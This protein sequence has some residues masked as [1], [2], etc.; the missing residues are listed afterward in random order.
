MKKKLFVFYLVVSFTLILSNSFFSS[1]I[2]RLHNSVIDLEF[3]DG[4]LTRSAYDNYFDWEN[5][6]KVDM[7]NGSGSMVKDVNLPWQLG[8]SNMGVPSE[9]IDENIED[10]YSKRMYTKRNNWELLYSNV[11]ETTSYKYIV[12]YN[13]LTGILRCFY[14]ILSDPSSTGTTNSVWGIGANTPT[15]LFNFTNT[16]AE[17][18]SLRKVT[19]AYI[20]TPVGSIVGTA[21]TSVGFQNQ[22]W[23]GLEIECA[24]DP[25][26]SIGSNKNFYL[27]GRAIDKITYN[28]I[29]TS[30]GNIEGSITST[31]PAGAGLSMNFSNMFN[32]SNSISITNQKSAIEATGD[33]IEEGLKQ[34]DSFFNSLWSNVKSN[35]GKWAVAGL[36]AGVKQGLSAIVS[37]GGS[38][39]ANVLGGLFSSAT[40]NNNVSKVDLKM[41]MNSEYK[42]EGEKV[43]PGWT[44]C[45][46]PIPGTKAESQPNKPLYNL[47]LGV[48]NL[49]QTPIVNLRIHAKN[50]YTGTLQNP[51][52]YNTT[53]YTF[54]YSLESSTNNIS[55]IVINP[56]VSNLLS[57]EN[58]KFELIA[59]KIPYGLSKKGIRDYPAYSFLNDEEY[60]YI[61]TSIGGDEE[62]RS[63]DIDDYSHAIAV[64]PSSSL[65]LLIRTSFELLNKETGSRLYVSKYFS[66][67]IVTSKIV[68]DIYTG[69]NVGPNV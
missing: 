44:D 14:Y 37:S 27:M 56:N 51:G 59:S 61:G 18:A 26:T 6:T 62:N 48:W 13:R 60:Y 45:F 58:V 69:S 4:V 11:S 17:D 31:A 42:F 49:I 34:N 36:E 23:Y 52:Y 43:L 8:V 21:Y 7:I 1:C 67:K 50:Q 54:S 16:I 41:V 46:L 10:E 28:G 32:K 3:H 57:I 12:L 55:N 19:P 33:K 40:S 22:V 2:D 64:N 25:Q 30:K 68:R 63:G 38:I 5:S 66:P 39:V 29:G 24:Y 9:W 35:A 47:P 53:T 65:N 20:S 15:S